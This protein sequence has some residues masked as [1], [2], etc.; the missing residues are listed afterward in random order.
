MKI[1][2]DSAALV[3]TKKLTLT[4]WRSVEGYTRAYFVESESSKAWEIVSALVEFSNL[5]QSQYI[6][7][8]RAE[9]DSNLQENSSD[10]TR[11]N[12]TKIFLGY[13]EVMD[14]VSIGTYEI[15]EK[16]FEPFALICECGSEVFIVKTSKFPLCIDVVSGEAEIRAAISSASS[17]ELIW[18][19]KI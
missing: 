6:G 11:E 9:V 4:W 13:R 7:V 16:F 3:N 8:E 2:F 12:L 19:R 5:S 1:R 18:D 14:V 15:S 17:F 10:N